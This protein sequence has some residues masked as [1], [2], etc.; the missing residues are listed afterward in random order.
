MIAPLYALDA[1]VIAIYLRLRHHS[2][3]KSFLVYHSGPEPSWSNTQHHGPASAPG[4][5]LD[6]LDPA[7]TT[8]CNHTPEIVVQDGSRWTRG[9]TGTM[10]LGVG[11]GAL[12]SHFYILL[13]LRARYLLPNF[14]LIFLF[15]YYWVYCDRLDVPVMAIATYLYLGNIHRFLSCSLYI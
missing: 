10:E 1:V 11:P 14:I 8:S 2:S 13:M 5:P 7:W 15:I 3:G 6:H 12:W 4:P 9:T